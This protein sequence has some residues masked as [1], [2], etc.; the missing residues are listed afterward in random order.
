MPEQLFEPWAEYAVV[1]GAPLRIE[2]RRVPFG[3]GAVVQAIRE[4]GM[5]DAERFAA[6]PVARVCLPCHVPLG[7]HGDWFPS[8]ASHSV[9]G[10]AA[11]PDKDVPE[12]L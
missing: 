2:F 12:Q 9:H 4:S 3:V 7:F 5:P 11:V 10:G 1:S 6:P 8:E